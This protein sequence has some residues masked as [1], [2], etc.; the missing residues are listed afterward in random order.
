MAF[1][2]SGKTEFLCLF[3]IQDEVSGE[4]SSNLTG[5]YLRQIRLPKYGML[6]VLHYFNNSKILL[7]YLELQRNDV[8]S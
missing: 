6:K 8:Q 2:F 5:N 4:K 7:T 1:L 3:A